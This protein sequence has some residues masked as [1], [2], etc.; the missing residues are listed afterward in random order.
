MSNSYLKNI[1]KGL[2]HNYVENIKKL[3]TPLSTYILSDYYFGIELEH[4]LSSEIKNEEEKIKNLTLSKNI[5]LDRSLLDK[6]EDYNI[7]AIQGGPSDGTDWSYNF[8]DDFIQNILPKI[9]KKIILIIGHYTLAHYVIDDECGGAN[10]NKI[11]NN[12]NVIL[13]FLQNYGQMRRLLNIDKLKAFPYGLNIDKQG[14][15]YY[16]DK[17]KEYHSSNKIKNI[18]INHLHLGANNGIREIFPKKDRLPPNIFYEKVY[19]S[20]F[21]LS[22]VGDRWDTYRNYECIGLE[23]IPISTQGSLSLIFN[24]NMVYVN[25]ENNETYDISINDNGH[26]IKKSE[27]MVHL[28]DKQNISIYK[29]PNCDLITTEYWNDYITNIINKYKS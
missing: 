25:E 15:N 6:I 28:Y 23:T 22:P 1:I 17:L 4:H 11:I 18:Y 7:I 9:N 29:K 13:C 3:I 10:I 27:H 2:D 19:D 26:V 8:Y 14:M 16:I 21:L 24:D 12:N 5:Y 20:K